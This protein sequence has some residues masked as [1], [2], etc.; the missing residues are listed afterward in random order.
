MNE[1]VKDFL[2]FASENEEVTNKFELLKDEADKNK[3]IDGTI[4]LAKE[5]GY[6]LSTDDFI[7]AE[8]DEDEL[9]GVAG[10]FK[11]CYCAI[12]GGGGSDAD[13]NT[14]ACVVGGYGTR[15]GDGDGRC[16]CVVEGS[17]NELV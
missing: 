1:K 11:S 17:G 16:L 10:G 3:V 2:K 7:Q 14:C 8:L 6:E 12:G 15:K 4:A 5:Y 9:D 13:G